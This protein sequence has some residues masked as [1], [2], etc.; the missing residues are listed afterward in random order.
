M[1][2]WKWGWIQGGVKGNFSF[3][4]LSSF[5]DGVDFH[6][7]G[8][9]M[10]SVMATHPKRDIPSALGSYSFGISYGIIRVCTVKE[11]II[12]EATTNR[13]TME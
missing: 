13:S 8:K 1:P 3:S 9:T 11:A 7:V 12:V 6:D 4:E 2:T 5:V 10:Y